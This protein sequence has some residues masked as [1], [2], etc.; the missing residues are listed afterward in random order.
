MTQELALIALA[1]LIGIPAAALFGLVI[2]VT[3]AFS[4]Y[5]DDD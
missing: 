1:A 2:M 4:E 5:D 3:V